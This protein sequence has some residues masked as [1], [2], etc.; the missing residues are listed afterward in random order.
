M[1]NVI[2]VCGVCWSLVPKKEQIEFRRLYLRFSKHPKSWAPK[3]E[4]IIRELKEFL[5]AGDRK[6]AAAAFVAEEG[7][8]ASRDA[9]ELPAAI[10]A[11]G[12]MILPPDV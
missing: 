2:L 3:G 12:G 1:I 9:A 11:I 5:A 10:D 4:K 6:I 7:T 8:R